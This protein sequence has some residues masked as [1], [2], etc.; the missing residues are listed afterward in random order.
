MS[1]SLIAEMFS[2]SYRGVA[3]GVLSWGV[4][5]GYGLAYVFGI[6]ITDADLLGY[7]WRAPYVL[8]G[9]PGVLIAAL[10]LLTFRDPRQDN[11]RSDDKQAFNGVKYFKKLV[12]SFCPPAM[13]ILLLAGQCQENISVNSNRAEGRR[14]STWIFINQ[15]VGCEYCNI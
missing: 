12:T 5:Y 15:T 3:N 9:L 1:G 2:A 14:L 8:A 11:K 4:Y 13:I 6:Y 7:S 10:L